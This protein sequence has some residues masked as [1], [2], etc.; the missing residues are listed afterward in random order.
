ME[1]P[2]ICWWWQTL[3]IQC[4]GHHC[5]WIWVY[6][7]CYRHTISHVYIYNLWEPLSVCTCKP[8]F[9]TPYSRVSSVLMMPVAQVA[10]T[11]YLYGA[12]YQP[13]KFCP[14]H[15]CMSL[16]IICTYCP[17]E[18][19]VLAFWKPAPL[20]TNDIGISIS[21]KILGTTRHFRSLLSYLQ[22]V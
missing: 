9:L 16:S 10:P 22:S 3:F 4:R 1:F 15:S 13:L 2:W 14:F 7:A 6:D 19:P 17:L 8:L 5:L 18:A 12:V 20:T 21:E 11:R